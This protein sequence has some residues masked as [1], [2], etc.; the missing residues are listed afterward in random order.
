MTY[1]AGTYMQISYISGK[2]LPDINYKYN[3]RIT[4]KLRH[5][6]AIPDHCGTKALAWAYISGKS[7]VPKVNHYI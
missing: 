6:M 2:S 3:F 7:L 1:V 4:V 5:S